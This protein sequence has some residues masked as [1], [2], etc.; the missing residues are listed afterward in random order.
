MARSETLRV[1]SSGASLSVRHYPG[2]GVPIVL[3]HGGPGM[4]DYFGAMPEMFSPPHHVISYDQ[5]GCGKSENPRTETAPHL[6][7]PLAVARRS[8]TPAVLGS[9][10]R[11]ECGACPA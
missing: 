11:A 3:L 9:R 8:L 6:S 10:G 5:R 4:G 7:I 1:S 2:D